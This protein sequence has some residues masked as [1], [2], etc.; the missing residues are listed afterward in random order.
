MFHTQCPD[1]RNGYN[2]KRFGVAPINFSTKIVKNNASK[3]I[4]TVVFRVSDCVNVC[5]TTLPDGQ[6]V[7]WC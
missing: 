1:K 3:K 5:A 6:H 4:I 7:R 2:E